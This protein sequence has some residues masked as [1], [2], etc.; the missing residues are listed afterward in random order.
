M[1]RRRAQMF[2][3]SKEDFKTKPNEVKLRTARFLGADAAKKERMMAEF[4]WAWRQT[5]LLQD[6]FTKDV[7]EAETYVTFEP[8]DFFFLGDRTTS[9]LKYRV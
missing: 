9:G 6:I 1:A 5:K 7:S 4:G 2:P 8:S 3:Q